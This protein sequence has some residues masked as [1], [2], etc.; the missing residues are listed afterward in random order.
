MAAFISIILLV[1]FGTVSYAQE[2]VYN[3]FGPGHEG[4]DYNYGLGW[5]V[6]GDSV[7]EQYGVEQAM[8]FQSMA[9]GTVTDI[10][11]AFFYVPL[12]ALPDTVTIRLA[13]NPY[14]LPPASAD[15][16]EEW[17]ITEFESWSQWSPPHHLVGNG[18]SQLQE[19][20]NYWLWAIGSE[21]TWTGWCMNINPALTCPHTIRREGEDWLPISNETASAFRV[22]V[23]P[24]QAVSLIGAGVPEGYS[25]SQN[26]PNPFNST[27]VIQYNLAVGS[28]A[29]LDVY[30]L[31]GRKVTTLV[32]RTQPAGQYSITWDARNLASG[33]YYCTLQ[34]DEYC[35]TRKMVLAK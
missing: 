24:I 25:L 4:W 28:R 1:M 18:T 2:T 9:E 17:S 32:N 8:G 12:S 7:P 31:L 13:Q 29:R 22:D 30:D 27:T 14:G 26:Y 23:G 15:I 21:T 6:A 34:A 19:G 35:E 5:T 16:M 3:N 10:W 33:M 20:G 11:V